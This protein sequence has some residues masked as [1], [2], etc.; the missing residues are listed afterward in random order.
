VHRVSNGAAFVDKICET[1][2]DILP[3]DHTLHFY[4]DGRDFWQEKVGRGG[5]MDYA[6]NGGRYLHELLDC[7]I[8]DLPVEDRLKLMVII[9]R[10]FAQLFGSMW[11]HNNW[12]RRSIFLF[13]AKDQKI[14]NILRPFISVD[15]LSETRQ[16]SESSG[17]NLS[18][19]VKCP[20]PLLCQLGIFLVEVEN[21]AST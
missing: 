13:L 20:D 5:R 21:G 16:N 19:I 4:S 2:D 17:S 14:P 6:A 8:W 1:F 11:M 3:T 18:R 9:A 12:T 10:A 15:S 7:G